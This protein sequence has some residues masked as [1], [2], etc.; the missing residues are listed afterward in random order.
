MMNGMGMSPLIKWGEHQYAQD[1]P[2][3][4]IGFHSLKKRPMTAIMKDDEQPRQKPSRRDDQ[5]EGEP[6]AHL[7][8]AI[9][10]IP[11]NQKRNERV[12]H[13][14]PTPPCVGECIFRHDCLPLKFLSSHFASSWDVRLLYCIKQCTQR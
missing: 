11:Q 4:V 14:P 5:Q 7:Q 12:D 9:R 10:E 2:K 8:A 1:H 13:L 3:L 6:V